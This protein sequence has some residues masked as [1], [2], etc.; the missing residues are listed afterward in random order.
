MNP[1]ITNY[2]VEQIMFHNF[3]YCYPYK[4]IG[5]SMLSAKYPCLLEG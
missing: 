5:S 4:C 1:S 2:K 3:Q